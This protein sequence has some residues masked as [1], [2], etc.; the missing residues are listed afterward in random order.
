M[1]LPQIK[2][3]DLLLYVCFKPLCLLRTK[4]NKKYLA[5]PKG[6]EIMRFQATYREREG[7]G[8]GGTGEE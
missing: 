7:G 2:R 1:R 4:E 6:T 8:G 3:I 5:N